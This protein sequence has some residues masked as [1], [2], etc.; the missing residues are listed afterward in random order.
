MKRL[1]IVSAGGD[2]PGINAVIRGVV[3]AAC[4]SGYEVLGILEGYNGILSTPM[5]YISLTMDSVSGI[6]VL[7][8]TLLKTTNR[9]DPLAYPILGDSGEVVGYSDRTKELASRISDLDLEGLIV[10]GGDGTQ[11]VSLR[12]SELGVNVIG[13]P[14][15]IDNDL[16]GTDYTFGFHTAVQTSVDVFDKL[17]ST[18][19]SHGRVM[20]MEVMGRDAGWIALYTALGGGAEVCLIPEI[21]Y[22]VR[23]VCGAILSRYKED[24]PCFAHI[25][26]A[27]GAQMHSGGKKVRLSVEALRGEIEK[28]LD[29]DIELRTM[30]LGYMQRGGQPIAFDRILSTCFGVRAFELLQAGRFGCM[31]SYRSSG[32]TDVPLSEAV[33]RYKYV[34]SKGDMVGVARKIGICFGD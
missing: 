21:P 23:K 2:C 18:A 22:D 14:K 19:E 26:L 11:K 7:G 28:H 13:V 34:D 10:I 31:V 12:L 24:A 8:G 30:V 9:H 3:K 33:S 16:W 1:A 27:E 20:I 32:I 6:H 17:V 25:V 29:K 4:G 5:R 15:T